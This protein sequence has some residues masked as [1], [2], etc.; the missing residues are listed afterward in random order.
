MARQNYLV[1]DVGASHGRA[2]V[3]GFDGQKFTLEEIH[4]FENRPVQTMGTLH[5]D[6]LRLFSELKI[7]IQKST[8]SSPAIT[9]L[10]VD[11]WGVDFGLIDSQGK[12]LANPINYR[13]A[14]GYDM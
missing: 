9:S 5:W 14:R 2:V 11:T 7:G 13:D 4:Q 1:F 6:V 8:K 10:G 3:A 12:L